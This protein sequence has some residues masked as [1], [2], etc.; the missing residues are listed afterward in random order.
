MQTSLKISFA[1]DAP[2]SNRHLQ[3]ELRAP[4]AWWQIDRFG[5][6]CHCLYFNCGVG[7]DLLRARTGGKAM[8]GVVGGFELSHA[9]GEW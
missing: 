7:S 2:Q 3:E 1:A 8:G 5:S 6:E 4:A 9:I